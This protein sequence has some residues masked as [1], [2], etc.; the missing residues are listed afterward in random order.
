M[1]DEKRNAIFVIVAFLLIFLYGN[2]LTAGSVSPTQWVSGWWLTLPFG[3]QTTLIL[4]S[5]L[6]LVSLFLTGGKK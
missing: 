3:I 6:L 4:V 5:F 1:A 2:R